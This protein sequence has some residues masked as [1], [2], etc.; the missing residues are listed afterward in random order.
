MGQYLSIGIIKDIEIEKE[1]LDDVSFEDLKSKLLNKGYDLDLFKI[2]TQ[3]NRLS[4]T[5]KTELLENELL[6]F[7]EKTYEIL[8]HYTFLSDY[9]SVL[10]KLKTV[11]DFQA[12]LGNAD[13]YDFQLD[14]YAQADRIYMEQ[15]NQKVNIY[16]NAVSFKMAGKIMIESSDGLFDLFTALLQKQLSDF[17]LSKTLKV[18]VTG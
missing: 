12:F 13:F 1:N 3:E 6:P 9:K 14:N 17:E 16:F 15:R 11:T 10:E 8:S 18:Y 5:I 7:L 2:E 4:G